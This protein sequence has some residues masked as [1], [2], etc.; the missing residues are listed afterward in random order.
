VLDG[1]E[2]KLSSCAST[3]ATTHVARADWASAKAEDG[4]YQLEELL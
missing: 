3:R 4:Y 1:V 2:C